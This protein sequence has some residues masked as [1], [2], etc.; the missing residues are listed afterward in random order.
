[1]RR[2]VNAAAGGTV[3][4][5]S[6]P[7]G[8]DWHELRLSLTAAALDELET[9]ALGTLVACFLVGVAV[10]EAALAKALG[11]DSTA[12]LRRAGVLVDVDDDGG[13][14]CCGALQ[15]FPILDDDVI[16]TDWSSETL[17]DANDAVMS[18]GTESLELALLAPRRSGGRAS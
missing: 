16:A 17:L 15:L 9:D 14:R 2:R 8:R 4:H 7:S 10:A 3:L 11:Q 1:M 18:V 6:Y 5:R 13:R 12:Q